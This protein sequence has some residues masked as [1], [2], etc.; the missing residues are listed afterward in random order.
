MLG[1]YAPGEPV[2]DVDAARC[3]SVLNDMLDSW[4]NES[5]TCYA[6]SEQTFDLVPGVSQY[7]IGVTPYLTASS[8]NYI[9]ASSGNYLTDSATGAY[10]PA[11]A[12]AITISRPL[13]I[14]ETPGSAY[15]RD[16]N[17]NKYPL[18]IVGRT[19]WNLIASQ[20]VT[21]NIPDTMFY[22]NQYPLAVLNIFPVPTLSYPLFF[23]SMIQLGNF[24]GYTSALNLPPGYKRALAS[25]LAV[26]VK[27]YFSD[28]QLTPLVLDIAA[29][30]KANVKRTNIRI[31]K[32]V[33]DPEIV[34]NAQP[35]YNVYTDRGGS[36]G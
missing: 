10:A 7:L 14:I 9:T 19:Q 34:S 2:Q 27:P 15:I 35:T 3:L 32:A 6:I 1:V 21:S 30:S 33:F 11:G 26:N 20:Q 8:G 36:G 5:L 24:T 12:Q 22:D 25:N 17:G 4:S 31:P 13:R 29:T 16:A 28:G 18:D 23:D